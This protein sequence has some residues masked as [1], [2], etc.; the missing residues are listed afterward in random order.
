MNRYGLVAGKQALS[1]ISLDL[2]LEL[3]QQLA[4]P[5]ELLAVFTAS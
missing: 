2:E 1:L 3:R 5:L 4:D